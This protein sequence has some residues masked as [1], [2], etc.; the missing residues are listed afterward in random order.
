MVHSGLKVFC[1][2]WCRDA[3]TQWSSLIYYLVGSFES[4]KCMFPLEPCC[5]LGFCYIPLFVFLC[6]WVYF[7]NPYIRLC[8]HHSVYVAWRNLRVSSS[9]SQML[10]FDKTLSMNS[11]TPWLFTYWWYLGLI[12]LLN[13]D[14]YFNFLL[15]TFTE[16]LLYTSIVLDAT[17]MEWNKICS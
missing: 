11:P 6:L 10:W 9:D 5:F 8:F 16:H 12:V 15:D 2:R 4:T 13:S 17:I 7:L 14:L 3:K 1:P